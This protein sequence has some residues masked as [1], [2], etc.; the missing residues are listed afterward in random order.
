[1]RS[2]FSPSPCVIRSTS[3]WH[4][5][6]ASRRRTPP[7]LTGRHPIDVSAGLTTACPKIPIVTIRELILTLSINSFGSAFFHPQISNQ[8]LACYPNGGASSWLPPIAER[9]RWGLGSHPMPPKPP[10]IHPVSAQCSSNFKP[11]PKP[12]SSFV[13]PLNACLGRRRNILSLPYTFL[14]LGIIRLDGRQ[15]TSLHYETLFPSWP[16]GAPRLPS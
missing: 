12:M 4:Q 8:A 2:R 7:D 5:P 6:T 13:D 1:M 3:A 9:E 14:A 16:H 11:L 15:S 10:S